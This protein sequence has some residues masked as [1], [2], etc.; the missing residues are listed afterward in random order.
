MSRDL[1]NQVRLLRAPSNLTLNVS[2]D[3]ASATSLGSLFQCFTT[4]IVKDFF[5]VSN[6]NLLSFSFKPLSLV[7]SEQALL[8]S[9]SPSFL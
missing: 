2:M 4:L 5:V 8:K 9:L 6:L 1:F 7:L 3:G